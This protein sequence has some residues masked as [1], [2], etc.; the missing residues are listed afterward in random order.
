[1]KTEFSLHRIGLLLRADWIEYKRNNLFR[2]I[3]LPAIFIFSWITNPAPQ[4]LSMMIR[5][6]IPLVCYGF[7]CYVNKKT[8]ASPFLYYT[9]PANSL[10][11][12]CAL[13]IEGVIFLS[14]SSLI[15]YII[16]RPISFILFCNIVAEQSFQ[17]AVLIGSLMFLAHVTFRKLAFPRFLLGLGLSVVPFL[18]F[19][20]FFSFPPTPIDY[21]EYICPDFTPLLLLS[22][23]YN[24]AM[25]VASVIVFYIGYL[26]LKEYELK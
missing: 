3:A 18:A 4:I 20:Y 21:V 5:L 9:L 24:L 22:E 7:C 14:V 8:H 10:E 12:F 6:V 26:K 11:K 25:Y 2:L 19:G 1:M 16:I 23:Y 15:I 17:P 13:I